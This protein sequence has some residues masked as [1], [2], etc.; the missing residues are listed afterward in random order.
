MDSPV[1]P[2]HSW[3]KGGNPTHRHPRGTS[4]SIKTNRN[5]RKTTNYFFICLSTKHAA[6]MRNIWP[7]ITTHSPTLVQPYLSWFKGGIH[8]AA[9]Q[10]E[11]IRAPKQSEIRSKH[12]SISLLA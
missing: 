7:I 2:T 3:L 5:T 9:T 4:S 11:S 6:I 10:G 1:S 12:L 8:A